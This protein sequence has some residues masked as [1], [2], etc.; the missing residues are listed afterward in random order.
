MEQ[1]EEH[2]AFED[3]AAPV[4]WHILLI[5]H[6]LACIVSYYTFEITVCRQKVLPLLSK[7]GSGAL[8]VRLRRFLRISVEHRKHV[9]GPRVHIGLVLCEEHV[10]IARGLA[11]VVRNLLV[12]KI[13][14]DRR[15]IVFVNIGISRGIIFIFAVDALTILLRNLV[16]LL[17]Q[18]VREG[19]IGAPPV[20]P[21]G[22]AGV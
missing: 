12:G 16:S 15:G 18:F 10:E 9:A 4:C 5:F 14:I 3:F 22:L 20:A 8:M 13:I 21:V 17:G 7:I 11:Y 19:E 1:L 6:Y 2:R